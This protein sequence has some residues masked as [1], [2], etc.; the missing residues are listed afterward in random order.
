MNWAIRS[1]PLT[2]HQMRCACSRGSNA[3]RCQSASKQSMISL[4]LV[5]VRRG[6]GVVARLGQVLRRPVERFHEGRL[7]V[8]HHRLLVREAEGGIAVLH[9]DAGV[10]EG[11]A[12]GLV[13]VLAVAAGGIEHHPDL[14]AA[15]LRGDHGLEQVRVGEDE[16]F[17]PERFCSPHRSRRGWA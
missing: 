15:T 10:L 4:D 5:T 9:L 14:H 17:D 1:R 13:V 12:G 8:D 16:H 2:G 11:L 6:D 3:C 7:V